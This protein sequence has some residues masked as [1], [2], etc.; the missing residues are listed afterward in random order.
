[1][2]EGTKGVRRGAFGGKFHVTTLAE[3]EAVAVKEV[4]VVDR[5]LDNAVQFTILCQCFR[6]AHCHDTQHGCLD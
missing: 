2:L 6:Y 1:M 5:H 3:R 4:E